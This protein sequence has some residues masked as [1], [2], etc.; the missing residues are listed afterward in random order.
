MNDINTLIGQ[1][2]EKRKIG[3]INADKFIDHIIKEHDIRE[4]NEIFSKLVYNNQITSKT[5]ET[6]SESEKSYEHL[7]H[8]P[9][10]KNI[11]PEE[12]TKY[13]AENSELPEWAD[14]KQIEM[15]QKTFTLIGPAF[16][17]S[18]FC[19]SLP[20]CYACGRG[21]EILYKTGR[22][23][24]QPRRRIAQTAQFVLD[25]MSP[26]GFELDGR[27]IATSIKVR[28]VHASI[29]YYFLRQVKLKTI[30]YDIESSGYPI[31]QEDLLGT[32][33][34]FS[35]VVIE[36][37]E[38]LGFEITIE[39]KEAILHLWKCVGFLIG[40]EDLTSISNYEDSGK[41]WNAIL[42]S[43]I[44]KTDAGESLSG[45]LVD[46]LEELIPDKALDGIVPILMH[47]LMGKTA[48]DTL[49]IK[50][51]KIFRPLSIITIILGILL[52]KFR[53]QNKITKITSQYVNM[54]LMVAL[55]K[56]I[57]NGEDTGIY[58]P[59]SLKQDWNMDNKTKSV[60]NT[61]KTSKL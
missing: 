25:V 10:E 28:L 60:F 18:Y 47:H 43:E 19:K 37:M 57:A 11:F 61:M 17:M 26:G 54:V 30:E 24:K 32:M 55:E 42:S 2:T 1:L 9:S 3:D 44:A 15:A 6:D 56:Y 31:N 34:A 38:K 51:P 7:P 13:I 35:F 49:N 59:P 46:F 12:F 40:V 29:R 41:V 52:L 58:I 23:T 21:S 16:I 8:S 50:T 53:M 4:I 45:E 36:G 22:L 14:L 48:S 39:Q 33:L 27:G 20:E 5:G